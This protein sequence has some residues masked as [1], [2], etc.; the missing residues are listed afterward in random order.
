MINELPSTVIVKND[1]DLSLG[2]FIIIFLELCFV[3]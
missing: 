3:F 1:V 2:N